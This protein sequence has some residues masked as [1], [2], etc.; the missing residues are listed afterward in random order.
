MAV[1]RPED[2]HRA[3][4]DAFNAGNVDALLALNEPGASLVPQPGQ[5]ITGAPAIRA[6][7]EGFLAL[8]GRISLETR[9]AVLNG[10]LALT[11]GQWTLLGTA[12]DGSPVEMAGRSTEVRRRQADG[13]WLCVIDNPFSAA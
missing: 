7:L 3:F 10:D 12:P 8:K 2:Y 13:T 9:A 6:A 4:M 5:I 1:Q 11:I